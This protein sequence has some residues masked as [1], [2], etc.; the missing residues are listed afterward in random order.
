MNDKMKDLLSYYDCR[1]VKKRGNQFYSGFTCRIGI[2][3]LWICKY[4]IAQEAEECGYMLYVPKAELN[5]KWI[6]TILF[7]KKK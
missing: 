5:E 4:E 3:D 1:N 7:I 2:V 6:E